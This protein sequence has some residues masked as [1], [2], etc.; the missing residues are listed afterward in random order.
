MESDSEGLGMLGRN[1]S[2]PSL[3]DLERRA[4]VSTTRTG[5]HE[6]QEKSSSDSSTPMSTSMIRDSQPSN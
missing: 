4:Q 6:G 2:T 3:K 1:G 5:S